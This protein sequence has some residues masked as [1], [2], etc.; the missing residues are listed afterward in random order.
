MRK[1]SIFISG[2]AGGI[3][4]VTAKLFLSKGW[5]V[6]IG[7]IKPDA[8]AAAA[9]QAHVETFVH[10]VRDYDSWTKALDAFCA[11]DDG[12]LDVLVNNAGVL[13]FG[14]LDDQDPAS[15]APLIDINVKGVVYGSH[16]GVKHLAKTKDSTLVNLG[17]SASLQSPP[18]Q[19]LYAATKFAVRGLSEALLVAY[20]RHGVRVSLI[21]PY[22]VDTPMLDHDT[23]DGINYRAAVSGGEI[24]DPQDVADRILESTQ[25]DDFHFPVGELPRELID[26]IRPRFEADKAKWLQVFGIA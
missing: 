16:A 18:I 6:G 17:S 3:G 11:P 13:I 24:L 26:E 2:G 19:A 12:A 14:W 8:L 22:C 5:R 7:D 23:P 10:D 4:L 20:R 25:S 1:R 21:E 9:A 15:F